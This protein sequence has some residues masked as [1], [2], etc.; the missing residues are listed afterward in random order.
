MPT[1][2]AAARSCSGWSMT[3]SLPL[4]YALLRFRSGQQRCDDGDAQD[5]G[6]DAQGNQNQLSV[7]NAV[8]LER[9]AKR[10]FQQHV[11]ADETQHGGQAEVQVGKHAQESGE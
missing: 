9:G 2:S 5:D 10:L 1:F 11:D 7:T 8:R 3:A 4:F 6:D